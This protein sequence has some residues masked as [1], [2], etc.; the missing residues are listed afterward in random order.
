MTNPILPSGMPL[1]AQSFDTI[2]DLQRV[3]V[4]QK[5]NEQTLHF[6][7]SAVMGI[8]KKEYDNRSPEDKI[9]FRVEQ[10]VYDDN[11]IVIVP[12][13]EYTK[14]LLVKLGMPE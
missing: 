2:E 6:I 10:S 11:A 4:G 3:M 13:N 5:I 12:Q 8:L 7:K 1:G 14:E 9:S